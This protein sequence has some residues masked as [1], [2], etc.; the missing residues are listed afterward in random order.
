[1]TEQVQ[2]VDTDA[3]AAAAERLAGRV[4]RTPLIASDRLSDELGARVLLKAENLQHTG[5]FKVRGLI[6]AALGRSA[7]GLPAGVTTFSAGNAAAATAFAARSLGVPAVVCMPPGAVPTKVEAVRRYGGEIIFTE[8]LVGTWDQVSKDRGYVALHPF[9]DP[10]VIAGHATIGTEILA[11]EPAPDLVVVPVGGGGLISGVAS[12]LRLGGYAGRIVGVEPRQANAVSYGLR[13]DGPVPPPV[14][15]ASLA[16][17]LA[18]PFAGA[19]TLAHIRARVDGIVEIGE[20]EIRDGWW[21]MLDASKL[22]VEPSAAVG[23]AAIRAG[24]VEVPAGGTV[25]LVLSGGNA[26]RAALATLAGA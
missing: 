9:D 10:Y 14:K 21:A 22:F 1:V 26:G 13:M 18:P 20:D 19:N 3:L 8:D 15:Q 4:V 7:G 5:S 24:L 11:D 17:G 2:L 6:N 16:D 23:L 12:G 25:V